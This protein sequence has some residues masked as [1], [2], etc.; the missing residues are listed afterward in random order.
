MK[1]NFIILRIKVFLSMLRMGK[2]DEFD[3]DD[4]VE[5]FEKI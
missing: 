3:L 5:A 4:N 2:I 1:M